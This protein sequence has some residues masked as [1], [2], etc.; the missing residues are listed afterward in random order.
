MNIGIFFQGQGEAQNAA[1]Q[2]VRGYRIFETH[3]GALHPNTLK[4][5]SLLHHCLETI[6]KDEER[7]I[8]VE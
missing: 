7:S 5:R 4:A 3:L 8:K 1:Q 2:F 6:E